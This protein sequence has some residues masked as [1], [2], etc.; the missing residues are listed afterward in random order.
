MRLIKSKRLSDVAHEIP[1]DHRNSKSANLTNITSLVLIPLISRLGY[2]RFLIGDVNEPLSRRPDRGLTSLFDA[3][4]FE[5]GE[6]GERR[7]EKR[8][9]MKEY[10]KGYYYF[11]NDCIIVITDGCHLWGLKWS[12]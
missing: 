7:F 8:A 12:Y 2:C 11:L 5:R 9:D 4:L 10:N 3:K 1:I 6:R